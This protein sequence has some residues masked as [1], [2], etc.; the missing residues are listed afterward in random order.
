MI[1]VYRKLIGAIPL[2]HTVKCITPKIQRATQRLV[3]PRDH[4]S[5][6]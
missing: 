4:I 1:A 6:V 2:A 5:T 3:C